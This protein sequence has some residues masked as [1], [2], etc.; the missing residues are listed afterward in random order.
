MTNAISIGPRGESI[1]AN[2]LPKK[3]AAYQETKYKG[4]NMGPRR[5][6]LRCGPRTDNPHPSVSASG[7]TEALDT[8][9]F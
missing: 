6:P 7:R 3:Y 9:A 8:T 5:Y 2:V 4:N 1:K